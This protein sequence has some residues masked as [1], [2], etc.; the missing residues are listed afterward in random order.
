[1]VVAAAVFGATFGAMIG[2]AEA[3]S[4]TFVTTSTA[5]ALFVACDGS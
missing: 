5:F 1:M 3:C 2:G 4:G